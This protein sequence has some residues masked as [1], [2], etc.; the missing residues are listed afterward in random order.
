MGPGLRR[1]GRRAH[2]LSR[3]QSHRGWG[4]GLREREIKCMSRGSCWSSFPPHG[5]SHLPGALNHPH[6]LHSTPAQF[7]STKTQV[8]SPVGPTQ[9]SGRADWLPPWLLMFL[10]Y[11]PFARRSLGHRPHDRHVSALTSAP[12]LQNGLRETV[13]VSHSQGWL[14]VP[15]FPLRKPVHIVPLMW[16]S[17]RCGVRSHLGHMSALCKFLPCEASISLA[18]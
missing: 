11:I 18:L 7:Q 14:P 2:T 13:R 9:G 8:L 6:R 12:H 4:P 16:E 10:N 5:P 15:S 1:Q 3:P 17:G